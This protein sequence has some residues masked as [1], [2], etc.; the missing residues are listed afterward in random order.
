[1]RI[2]APEFVLTAHAAHPPRF[3]RR[4]ICLAWSRDRARPNT[5]G[6]LPDMAA[7]SAPAARSA[8]FVRP[9]TATAGRP[10]P[11]AEAPVPPA[12]PPPPHDPLAAPAAPP[13]PVDPQ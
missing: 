12:L 13:D 5:V 3:T 7:P 9:I 2:A 1:M 10:P 4:W 11:P 8:P 6:P